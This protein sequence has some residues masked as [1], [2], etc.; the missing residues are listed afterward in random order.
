MSERMEGR[1]PSEMR[2]ASFA[3]GGK[4][5]QAPKSGRTNLGD[6]C[7]DADAGGG[8]FGGR[9]ARSRLLGSR[10][11]RFSCCKLG[12]G[13]GS[14]G[15]GQFPP[16]RRF[17][18]FPIKKKNGTAPADLI[19][20]APGCCRHTR[21]AYPSDKSDRSRPPRAWEETRQSLEG[22]P[23]TEASRGRGEARGGGT[24]G[25]GGRC[26]RSTS[27]RATVPFGQGS[28]R[29]V[30]GTFCT[31][32]ACN[33]NPVPMNTRRCKSLSVCTLIM[34]LKQDAGGIDRF[35]AMCSTF[36]DLHPV[37]SRT[38]ILGCRRPKGWEADWKTMAR[39]LRTCTALAVAQL[40]SWRQSSS[41]MRRRPSVLQGP[42]SQGTGQP[43]RASSQCM[44]VPVPVP[45]P[46]SCQRPRQC[47]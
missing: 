34:L 32:R 41:E 36:L 5:T 24:F 22:K 45:V 2:A 12:S 39:G 37:R 43:R 26:E 20:H 13:S 28:R 14:V 31:A 17:P 46:S 38:P 15:S 16:A 21:T 47:R 40:L 27:G 33:P 44:P 18:A 19:R 4:S 11:S 8:R 7:E 10:R 29:E 30:L 6:G 25:D 35:G 23:N 42:G 1:C 9:K 3:K